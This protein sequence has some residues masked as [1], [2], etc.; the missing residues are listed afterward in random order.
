MS[1]KSP[2][3][4][5]LPLTCPVCSWNPCVVALLTQKSEALDRILVRTYT[6]TSPYVLSSHNARVNN[7]E[8]HRPM[9]RHKQDFIFIKD[10]DLNLDYTILIDQ[11]LC[12]F[13]CRQLL[14]VR[15]LLIEAIFFSYY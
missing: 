13:S 6:M 1:L 5:I 8:L 15:P 3:S 11:N 7:T 2:H 10:Y 4:P 12:V 14:T 9:W